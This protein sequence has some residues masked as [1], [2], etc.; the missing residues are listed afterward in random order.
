[1]NLKDFRATLHEELA[2]RLGRRPGYSLRSFA[3]DIGV[4]V[5]NLSQILAGRKGLSGTRARSV[6]E[7]LGMHA[8]ELEQF[9]LAAESEPARSRS[10]RA[11]ARKRLQLLEEEG[12]CENR[13]PALDSPAPKARSLSLDA[14]A[15]VSEWE[16]SAILEWVRVNRREALREDHLRALSYKL[17]THPYRVGVMLRRLERLG[18]IEWRSDQQADLGRFV[19]D[20]E[21][22]L[23]PDGISSEA[24]RR[25]HDSMLDRAK[26]A[27]ILDPIDSRDFYGY[28][29]AMRTEKLP[30]VRARIREFYQ[31]LERE[32][33]D[34]TESSLDGEVAVFHLGSQVIRLLKSDTMRSQEAPKE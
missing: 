14:Y 13:E 7:R 11:V 3:R 10:A 26:S 2:T 15:L 25:F 18:L 33:G 23:S 22:V 4:G 27:L 1:M 16:H 24:L 9:V 30:A 8:A 21:V 17:D 5:A 31:A 20:Q 34:P 12:S 6:G 28:T 29:M 19:V 32:F